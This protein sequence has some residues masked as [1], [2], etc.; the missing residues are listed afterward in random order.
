MNV[1]QMYQIVLILTKRHPH[2]FTEKST[3]LD[4]LTK[5]SFMANYII[6]VLFLNYLEI[7]TISTIFLNNWDHGV[8]CMTSKL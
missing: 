7:K 2:N 4:V 1:L 8:R 5:V 3:T 6:F